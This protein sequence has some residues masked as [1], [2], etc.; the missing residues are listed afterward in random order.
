MQS[1]RIEL[2]QAMPIFGAIRADVLEFML[3]RAGVLEVGAGEYF[4]RENDEAQSMFVLDRGSASVIKSWQGR[5]CVLHQLR[6]GDC[7][8]EMALMDM[9]PRSASVRADEACRVIELATANFMELYSRDLEQFALIQMNIGREV[10][11]RLR[12]ADK[13]VFQLMMDRER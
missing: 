11:R 13:L 8:G 3:A 1:A 5:E 7:F 6:A 10:C 2:L 4:F 9:S 12:A